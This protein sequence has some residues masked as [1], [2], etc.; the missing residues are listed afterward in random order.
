M[1]ILKSNRSPRYLGREAIALFHGTPVRSQTEATP[2]W[3]TVVKVLG[4]AVLVPVVGI[5]GWVCFVAAFSL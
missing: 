3:K 4:L 1:N 2:A 5:A